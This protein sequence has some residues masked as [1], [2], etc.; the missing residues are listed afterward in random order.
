MVDVIR[1]WVNS[2]HASIDGDCSSG[3]YVLGGSVESGG[4]GLCCA[5]V[6]SLDVVGFMA[7]LQSLVDEVGEA[8]KIH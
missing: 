7:D 6:F 8:E 5:A 3:V 4:A 1:R 2:A